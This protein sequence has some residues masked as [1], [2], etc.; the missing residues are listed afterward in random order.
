MKNNFV[1]I[2]GGGIDKIKTINNFIDPYL[3]D[4][5]NNFLKDMSKEHGHKG[6]HLKDGEDFALPEELRYAM[7]QY[8]SKVLESAAEAYGMDF[9]DGPASDPLGFVIH[10]IGSSSDP[11]TDV[12]EAGLEA[13]KPGDEQLVGWRD[14]WDGYLACNIYIN[15]NYSGG[16]V[17]FPEIPYEFKP[18]S[19]T[20]VMWAGNKNFIH[21]VRDPIDADRFTITRWIKFKD[22]DKYAI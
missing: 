11:H 21:G 1:D 15:D 16:Q 12:L 17:Y 8:N 9:V 2:F 14:A 18:V 7:Y 4:A 10:R 5:F 20:L 6:M 19:N 3:L 13:Q 22:F